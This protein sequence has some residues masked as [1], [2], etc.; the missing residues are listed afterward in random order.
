MGTTTMAIANFVT[1]AIVFFGLIGLSA[2]A[3]NIYERGFDKK[4]R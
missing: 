2:V 3:L 4:R 1:A